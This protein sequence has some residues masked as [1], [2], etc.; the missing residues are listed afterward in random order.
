MVQLSSQ[1][2]KQY[3]I[4][5]LTSSAEIWDLGEVTEAHSLASAGFGSD[6]GQNEKKSYAKI[7]K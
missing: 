7:L 2:N 5:K 4:W 6:Q 3:L 1:L